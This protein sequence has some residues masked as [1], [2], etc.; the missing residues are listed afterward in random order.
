MLPSPHTKTDTIDRLPQPKSLLFW[1]NWQS[2]YRALFTSALLLLAASLVLFTVQAVQGTDAVIGWQP[3]SELQEVVLSLDNFTKGIL[4]FNVEVPSYV[5][6]ERFEPTGIAVNLV[7]AYLYTGLLL[8]GLVLL[9]STVTVLPRLWYVAGMAVFIGW[10]AVSKL[11]LLQV[12]GLTN[13]TF[14]IGVLALV[15]PVSYYFHA[16]RPDLSFATRLLTF[17]CLLA[18][19]F[20]AGGY[21]S[22]I[23]YP[24]LSVLGYGS[25][26]PLLLTVLFIVLVSPEIVRGFLHLVTT[27]GSAN[28]LLHFTLLTAI[29]L[30]NLLLRYAYNTGRIDWEFFYLNAFAV[31]AVSVVLGIWGFRQ[32]APLFSRIIADPY[33][34]FLYAGLAVIA[35][36]T[37]GYAFATGNDPVVEMFEDVILFSH[38]GMGLAF[39]LYVLINFRMP[40]QQ[41]L[42]V[43]KVLFQPRQFPFGFSWGV[44]GMVMLAF[45]L[46]SGLFPFYQAVAGYN[47]G[48][49]DS[50][51]AQGNAPLAESYYQMALQYEYRNHKANYSVA[52][53][54]IQE[55]NSTKAAE[56][57][58]Q[59][60][61]KQPQPHTYAKLSN[62]YL[63]ENLF[64]ESIFTLKDGIK[65]F[66]E[67]GELYNNLA[68]LYNRTNV[69]DSAYL[70][71]EQAERLA[72]RPEVVKT[73]QLAFWVKAPQLADADSLWQATAPSD[74]ISA[75]NNRLLLAS[76][77]GKTDKGS[78]SKAVKGDSLLTRERF[79]YLFNYVL[80]HKTDADTT[81]TSTLR[82]YQEYG[83]NVLFSNDLTLAEAYLEYYADD[84]AR[85]LELLNGLQAGSEL[86]GAFFNRLLGLW[87]L[88]NDAPRLAANRFER[89]IALGDTAMRTNRGIALAEAGLFAES[90]PVWQAEK[91]SPDPQARVLAR[92]METVSRKLAGLAADSADDAARVM[93]VH[94]SRNNP[95][96]AVPAT[97]GDAPYRGLAYAELAEVYL[98]T[99]QVDRATEAY[100]AAS[101]LLPDSPAVKELALRLLA[102]GGQYQ[103]LLSML[104]EA[105]PTDAA[106]NRKPYW[107]ALSY[108][109]T[110]KPALAAEKYAQ[111]VR[112]LPLDP[113]VVTDAAAFYR[114]RQKDDDRAYNILVEAIRLNPYAPAVHKAYIRQALEMGLTDYAEKGLE[115]FRLVTTSAD[116]GA[117]L[118]E[119]K[120]QKASVEK[121]L[122][123]WQ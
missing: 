87:Y 115:E 38:I 99:N 82:Q 98:G 122:S 26:V 100:R 2:P 81:L 65:A 67:N 36:S 44:G 91:F 77:A 4:N 25:T 109:H 53:L 40:M 39:F 60:L 104:N 3:E 108:Q 15:I 10:L 22:Q 103:K 78:F 45:L 8:L 42:P 73:N 37:I 20:F 48:I 68:L 27:S 121:R 17:T 117:F 49:A 35:V 110:G 95:Q 59:A 88:Q 112:R 111:A 31:L 86:R 94:L 101:G 1:Q 30:L 80:N 23:S 12:F 74:Y 33:L 119:Y 114:S 57:L 106:R 72:N 9:L 89:A 116:Y 71:Y 58:R 96:A 105:L 21:F 29:Y 5:V 62:L 43:H 90:L 34:S 79:A 56:Y 14:F 70:Y 11:D 50:Y 84:R 7:A 28:G 64:F 24:V 63:R 120:A 93:L 61:L 85:G 123:E 102:A 107:E 76:M 92:R 16:F 75:E 54:A 55:G 32:R 51:F 47:N 69:L 13:D 19:I 18:L 66:P 52:T 113:Q 118:P 41:G 97:V 83:A 6:I 46:E